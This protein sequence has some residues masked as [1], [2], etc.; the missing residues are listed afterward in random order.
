[1]KLYH[2]QSLFNEWEQFDDE[3]VIKTDGITFEIGGYVYQVGCA[4]EDENPD[5]IYF[6][7]R[8]IEDYK[9]SIDTHE[10][11]ERWVPEQGSKG[12]EK[13]YKLNCLKLLR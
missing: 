9:E 5:T 3:N 8:P 7:R 13:Y 11:V 10:V 1:M 6:S 12:F 4:D 2:A